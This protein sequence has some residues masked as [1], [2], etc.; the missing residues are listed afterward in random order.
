MKE[1]AMANAA[2]VTVLGR[3]GSEVEVKFLPSG[4]AVA[5]LSVACTPS[6]KTDTGWEDLETLWFQVSTFSYVDSLVETV[7]K[8]DLVSVTGR[9]STRSYTNKAGEEKT[10]LN[11][12]AQSVSL[13]QKN[14]KDTAEAAPF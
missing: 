4:K 11:I 10:V 5:N 3:A 13:V 7:G 12:D 8:G 2:T 14:K 1:K 9:L 6:K